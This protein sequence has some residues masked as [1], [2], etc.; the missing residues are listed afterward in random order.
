LRGRDQ[1]ELGWKQD[2]ISKITR[3]KWTIEGLAQAVECL[4]SKLKALNSNPI[5]PKNKK[6]LKLRYILKYSG[7]NDNI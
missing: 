3:A 7:Y 5:P 1:E 6:N 2:P 4:L